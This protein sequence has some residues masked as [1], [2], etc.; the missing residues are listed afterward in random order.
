MSRQLAPDHGPLLG[1][2]GA[3]APDAVLLRR[4]ID[5]W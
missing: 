4:V 2:L 1:L 3:A 5:R